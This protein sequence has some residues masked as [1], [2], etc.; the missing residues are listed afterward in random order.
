MTGRWETYAPVLDAVRGLS[1]PALRR[2]RSAVL[3]SHPS[4]ARGTSAEFVEYRPYRQGDDPR[5]ID[6]K[7]LARTDRVYTRLSQEQARLATVVVVDGSASMAYPP[8]TL[9]KWTYAR[10]LAVGLASVALHGGDPV[11]LAVAHGGGTRVVAPRTR[12]TVLD[13]MMRALDVDPSGSPALA[14]VAGDALRRG[15]R[16]VLVSDFLGDADDLLER[17]KPF[18][19]AG[20]EVYA[21]HVVDAG[22]LDPDPKVQLVT[23]PEEE[24]LRR[25]LLGWARREYARRFGEWRQ[26][27]ARRWRR[28]GAVY[29]LVVPDREPL[30]RTVRRITEGGGGGDVAGGMAAGRGA[31]LGGGGV[32]RGREGGRP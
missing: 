12:R 31:A 30:R 6:W 11:G 20:G 27:L 28:A 17:V 3:G 2:V 32:F 16:L 18:V 19:A 26:D 4:T 9:R 14:P 10:A 25:P 13:E 1:W 22:E 8:Q 7:L 29:T 24:G 21:V 23:D 5:R 15:G